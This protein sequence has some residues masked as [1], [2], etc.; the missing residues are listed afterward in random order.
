[1][2]IIQTGAKM[3]VSSATRI[4]YRWIKGRSRPSFTLES[5]IAVSTQRL[6]SIF[7]HEFSVSS[8]RWFWNVKV[9][10]YHLR[11]QIS[12][13][14]FSRK[15]PDIPKLF[16]KPY[17]EE[18]NSKDVKCIYKGLKFIYSH[19]SSTKCAHQKYLFETRLEN[20]FYW[21]PQTLGLWS[22]S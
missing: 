10:Q 1:M 5:K 9:K 2:E 7:F 22:V 17:L 4:Y 13:R 20:M 21:E 12:N 18:I 6:K 14:R 11:A 8:K 19:S 16:P 3:Y 15:E